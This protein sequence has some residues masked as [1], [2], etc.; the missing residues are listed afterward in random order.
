MK[1]RFLQ[2]KHPD[3]LVTFFATGFTCI[4]AGEQVAVEETLQIG[5]VNAMIL[6]ISPPLALVSGVHVR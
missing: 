6:Q 3:A 2:F 5:K 4:L 1:S